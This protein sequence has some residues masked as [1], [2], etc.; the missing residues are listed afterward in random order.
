[1][2]KIIGYPSM[3]PLFA[4]MAIGGSSIVYGFIMRLAPYTHMTGWVFNYIIAVWVSLL[5]L[6]GHVI[7]E[8]EKRSK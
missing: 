3:C 8:R 2:N 7:V 5:F 6:T 4:V 1:M